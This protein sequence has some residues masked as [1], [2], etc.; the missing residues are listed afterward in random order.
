MVKS[1][2]VVVKSAKFLANKDKSYFRRGKSGLVGEKSELISYLSTARS[3][4]CRP[5]GKSGQFQR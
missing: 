2:H 3:G 4:Q 1:D 5:D